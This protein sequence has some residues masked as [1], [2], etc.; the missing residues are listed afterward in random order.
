MNPLPNREHT[1]RVTARLGLS[2]IFSL[3][4]WLAKLVMLLPAI[5]M[6]ING[7]ID[8]L[9]LANGQPKDYHFLPL[10]KSEQRW[11]ATYTTR[12]T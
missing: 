2:D 3:L 9:V 12:S 7:P 4:P 6:A 10:H 1:L 5:Y 11:L 8:C